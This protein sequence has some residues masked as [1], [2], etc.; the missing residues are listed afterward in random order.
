MSVENLKQSKHKSKKLLLKKCQQQLTHM[1]SHRKNY[2]WR[3][4]LV[5]LLKINNSNRPGKLWLRQIHGGSPNDTYLFNVYILHLNVKIEKKYI[6]FN[7]DLRKSVHSCTFF[8]KYLKLLNIP[9]TRYTMF[10][11]LLYFMIAV[12]AFAYA[13]PKFNPSESRI[14]LQVT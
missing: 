2:F 9:K 14:T 7:N 3:E 5:N 11:H 12:L 10:K 4:F 1:T 8:Q 6:P 13:L